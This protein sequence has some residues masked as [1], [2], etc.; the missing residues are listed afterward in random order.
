MYI[1]REGGIR[2]VR[3]KT[4]LYR[5]RDEY[6]NFE[7]SPDYATIP[8]KR[9]TTQKWFSTLR[10]NISGAQYSLYF[11]RKTVLRTNLPRC[12]ASI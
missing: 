10:L 3:A 12:I 7:P 4:D 11:I 1:I 5:S 6:D 8:I 9:F 2:F